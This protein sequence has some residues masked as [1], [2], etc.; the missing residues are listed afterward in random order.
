MIWT[1]VPVMTAIDLMI[2][3]VT[4]AVLWRN[5]RKRASHRPAAPK[6]GLALILVGLLVV[7]LFYL[8]DLL[9]MYVLPAFIPMAE[10]MEVMNRPGF[11]GGCL[12]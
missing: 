7:G 10:S 3:A 2:I 8:L 6:A 1:S 9:S 4:V 12:V 5:F 11:A